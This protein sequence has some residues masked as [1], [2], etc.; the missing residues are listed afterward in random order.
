[1]LEFDPQD[2]NALHVESDEQKPAYAKVTKI[3]QGIRQH[4]TDIVYAYIFRHARH[5]PQ[6][7]EFVAD[8]D[9]HNPYAKLDADPTNDVDASRDGKIESNGTDNL[10]WRG[11]QYPTPPA[12]AFLAF[13]GPTSNKNVYIDSLGTTIT[14]YAPIKDTNGTAIAVL[15]VDVKD[16]NISKLFEQTALVLGV[17][18]LLSFFLI[19][20]R[21]AVSQRR[22]FRH[23]LHIMKLRHFVW[24]LFVPLCLSGAAIY[25]LYRHSVDVMK[26]QI[27]EQLM[28]IASTASTQF[29]A[30]DLAQLHIA[31]DM[32]RDAYQRVFTALNAVRR[33]NP[34][35]KYAYI[36][37]KSFAPDMME[38]VADADSNTYPIYYLDQGN[39]STDPV[40]P[41]TQYDILFAKGQI[42]AHGL[43]SPQTANEFYTDKWG[44]FLTGSAPIF[45]AKSHAIAFVGL[46]ME[47]SNVRAQIWKSLYP[48]TWLI[49]IFPLGIFAL[50]SFLA[51]HRITR[52]APASAA[53]R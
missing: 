49:A 3:L 41:G 16:T 44:T 22:L 4:N 26:M 9:S 47:I 13:A 25:G 21:M 2:I 51:L 35:I 50:T 33:Q 40:P 12:E 19:M 17:L 30:E 23:L 14:G 1:M 52:Q 20:A 42:F 38:F 43:E 46:D 45:D 27:A 53:R 6:A 8:A 29:D 39:V 5:D 7:L 10:S 34:D 28:T 11:Q 31:G 15:A 37:R 36:M 32:K 24:T 48:W 18:F